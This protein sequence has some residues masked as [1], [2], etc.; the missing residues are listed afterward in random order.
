MVQRALKHTVA[1]CAYDRGFHPR[2]HEGDPEATQS[3][4]KTFESAYPSRGIR[5]GENVALRFSRGLSEQKR[6]QV[7][8]LE[9]ALEGS[10]SDAAGLG[11]AHV[12]CVSESLG[13]RLHAALR[14]FASRVCA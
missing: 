2:A 4:S 3:D 13:V 6:G 7:V 5:R 14:R 11:G 12:G 8:D 10:G 1:A 9:K